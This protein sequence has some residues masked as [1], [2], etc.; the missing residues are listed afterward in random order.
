[1][2]AANALNGMKQICSFLGRSEATVLKWIRVSYADTIPIRKVDGRWESDYKAL[3][4]WR[5][6]VLLG[7]PPTPKPAKKQPRKKRVNTKQ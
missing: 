6:T 5:R 7:Q 1:M 4:K 3:S 2:V